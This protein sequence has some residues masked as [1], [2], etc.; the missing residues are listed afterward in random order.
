MQRLCSAGIIVIGLN[1]TSRIVMFCFFHL[2]SYFGKLSLALLCSFHFFL[3]N[4]VVFFAGFSAV[5]LS[6]SVQPHLLCPLIDLYACGCKATYIR[7]LCIQVIL[8]DRRCV[9]RP[10]SLSSLGLIG[11]MY[12]PEIAPACTLVKLLDW[13]QCGSVMPSRW[14]SARVC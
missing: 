14:R 11:C 1:S 7:M 13:H 10:Q 12:M 9:K 6:L 2:S 5:P 3:S 8:W 4:F